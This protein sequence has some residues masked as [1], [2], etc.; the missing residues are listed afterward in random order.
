MLKKNHKLKKYE[1]EILNKYY[2]LKDRKCVEFS[3][4]TFAQWKHCLEIIDKNGGSILNI[5][6]GYTNKN[7]PK[8]STLR[9]F[10]K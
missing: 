7:Y 6:Y 2:L 9:V 5:D 4:E 10:N 1:E 8:S 3:M